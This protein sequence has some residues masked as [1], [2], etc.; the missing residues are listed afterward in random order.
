MGLVARCVRK[1]LGVEDRS[2]ER[3]GTGS[4]F[5]E[6]ES[7]SL[8]LDVCAVSMRYGII[9]AL[10]RVSIQLSPGQLVAVL[11]SNG[12]GKSSLARIVAGLA[13]P[14]EG[15]ITYRG[16][17]I[18]HDG[19]QARVR[20][21][22]SL[23]PEGRG[24]LRNLTVRDN[25]ALGMYHS[26][27]RGAL[28]TRTDMALAMFPQL[29][30]LL[31]RRAGVLSG[32]ELQMLAIARALMAEPRLLVLDEPTMG[33]A[34]RIAL[35]VKMV[36]KALRDRGMGILLLE[37]NAVIGLSLADYV[38]VFEHGEVAWEGGAEAAAS[39]SELVSA[40]LGKVV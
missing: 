7:G 1:G 28:A 19:V 38:Y 34:P 17:D 39:R 9:E 6:T 3:L 14:T 18:T 12:A 20:G 30:P 37:Q 5:D 4:P 23:V 33:L 2:P 13:S 22:L 25:L 26:S 16:R 35:D 11:G 27:D 10:R 24:Q 15:T 29:V 36:L 8:L 21:G 40:Y 32:G 31:G